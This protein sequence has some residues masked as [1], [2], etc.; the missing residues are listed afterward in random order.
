MRK[1]KKRKKKKNRKKKKIEK[2]KHRPLTWVYV[3]TIMSRRFSLWLETL[4]SVA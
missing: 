4:S 1:K 3:A 2:K